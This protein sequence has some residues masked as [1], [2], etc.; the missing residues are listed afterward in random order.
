MNICDAKNSFYPYIFER[1]RLVTSQCLFFFDYLVKLAS[2]VGVSVVFLVFVF[3]N[4]KISVLTMLISLFSLSVISHLSGEATLVWNDYP[5]WIDTGSRSRKHLTASFPFW[6]IA[7]IFSFS[8][9]IRG[10][11]GSGL[12]TFILLFIVD[13][14]IS[15][16]IQTR[17]EEVIRGIRSSLEPTGF[18]GNFSPSFPA[19]SV[20]VKDSNSREL[21]P[22][23]KNVN[24]TNKKRPLLSLITTKNSDTEEILG[25]ATV[26]FNDDMETVFLNIPFCPPFSGVPRFDFEQTTNTEAL[27]KISLLQPFGVRLEVRKP[28]GEKLCVEDNLFVGIAFFA[29][30]QKH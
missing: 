12:L 30:F 25:E 3:F 15:F 5:L 9:M 4:G 7:L 17:G 13:K 6:L 29:F 18:Y 11:Y 24:V 8:L 10:K 27:V 20:A 28:D 21:N 14:S 2:W 19:S 22:D 16:S 23:V 26:E 1:R